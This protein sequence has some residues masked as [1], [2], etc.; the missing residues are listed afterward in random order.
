M[1]TCKITI[2]DR[3]TERKKER[4]G[5]GKWNNILKIALRAFIK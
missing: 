3:V 4:K 5:I 1:H 2:F